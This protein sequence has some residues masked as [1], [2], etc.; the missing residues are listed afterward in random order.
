M[1]Y[2]YYYPNFESPTSFKFKK[3]TVPHLSDFIDIIDEVLKKLKNDRLTLFNCLLVN[4]IWCTRTVPLLYENPFGNIIYSKY[5]IYEDGSYDLNELERSNNNKYLITRTLILCFDEIELSYFKKVSKINYD[6]HYIEDIIKIAAEYKPLFE[7][8]KYI[9]YFEDTKINNII[10]NWFECRNYK[11][12]HSGKHIFPIFHHSILRQCNHLK[13]MDITI[14]F[15][16]FNFNTEFIK[17]LTTKLSNLNFL[18]LK[19]NGIEKHNDLDLEFLNNLSSNIANLHIELP[20]EEISSI[21]KKQKNLKT[22]QLTNCGTILSNIF[23][24][25]LEF[26]KYSL[27]YLK[28]YS[29]NFQNISFNDLVNLSNLQ[30]LSFITCENITLD[31]VKIFNFTSFKLKELKITCRY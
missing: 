9:K 8:P 26:Q 31:Q 27:V 15:R 7:Y 16:N 21:I 28:F 19:H 11:Y 17:N 3:M 2:P 23:S 5:Y 10:A 14:S 6:Y 4:R 20:T 1:C 24:E 13:R 18:S 22:I 25:L 12:L 29:V 30:F